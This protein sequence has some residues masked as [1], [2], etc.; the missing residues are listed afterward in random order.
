MS[1]VV[2]ASQYRVGDGVLCL[3]PPR[4]KDGRVSQDVAFNGDADVCATLVLRGGGWFTTSSGFKAGKFGFQS[5]VTVNDPDDV[6]GI[7]AL[8]DDLTM[9]LADNPTMW[10]KRTKPPT[11][12]ELEGKDPEGEENHRRMLLPKSEEYPDSRLLMLYYDTDK[13]TALPKVDIEGPLVPGVPMVL[14]HQLPN[15]NW[16]RLDIEIRS[17][18][19]K[20]G[21]L[22]YKLSTKCVKIVLD[23][24][25]GAVKKKR[26]EVP[27]DEESP[28]KKKRAEVPDLEAAP[29]PSQAPQ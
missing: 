28:S 23:G 16:K 14:P 17:V 15:K 13:K 8:E 6:K 9:C 19:R 5:C 3:A 4:E 18:T 25:E 11:R 12:D 2:N 27:D 24:T 10:P 26:A 21:I 7:E 1:A 22:F 20:K 29:A